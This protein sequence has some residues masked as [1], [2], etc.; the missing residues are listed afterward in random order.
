VAGRPLLDDLDPAIKVLDGRGEEVPDLL[1]LLL[2]LFPGGIE[3]LT[4]SDD[5]LGDQL[6]LAAQ[7]FH[8]DP[9]SVGSV[10]H[11]PD[12]LVELPDTLVELPDTLVDLPD[13][14]VELPDTLIE[15]PDTLPELLEMLGGLFPQL[16]KTFV[17]VGD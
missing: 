17:E 12:T 13:T 1:H 2:V 9:G 10:L 14:L 15:L 6:D 16:A 7:V 5:T 11:P 4:D 3:T 8:Q